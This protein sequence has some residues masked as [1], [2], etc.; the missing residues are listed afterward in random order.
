MVAVLRSMKRH[1]LLVEAAALVRAACPSVR[2]LVVGDGPCRERTEK[3]V[4]ERGL[5]G[6]FIFTGH[7]TDIP[8]ILA[9]S[10]VVVLT[11]DRNEGVPQSLSQAMAMARPVVAAPIGSIP[12]LVVDGTTGLLAETGNAHSFALRIMQLLGND[13]L[14]LALGAAARDHILKGYTDN[15]MAQKTLE[16]Y[17]SLLAHKTGIFPTPP[18]ARNSGP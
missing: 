8:A 2:F 3:L 4:H 15:I 1:D 14:C 7:R 17:A 13:Q 10:D 11:S 9:L 6:V 16:F 12:E 18:G 5:A